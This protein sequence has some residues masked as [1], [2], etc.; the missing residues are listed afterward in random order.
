MRV[1]LQNLLVTNEQSHHNQPD[2]LH[3]HGIVILM[4]EENYENVQKL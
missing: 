1:Q 4:T 3:T 2:L